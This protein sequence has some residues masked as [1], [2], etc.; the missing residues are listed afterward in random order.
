MLYM[1]SKRDTFA[2]FECLSS[3]PDATQ[4]LGAILPVHLVLSSN[5]RVGKY[6][7]MANDA[8]L[9]T[10]LAGPFQHSPALTGTCLVEC[11]QG[12][13]SSKSEFRTPPVAGAK[14]AGLPCEA[15]ASLLWVGSMTG[16][17]SVPQ[18]RGSASKR[19]AGSIHNQLFRIALV[20]R[21]L[22]HMPV[23]VPCDASAQLSVAQLMARCRTTDRSYR[24]YRGGW[25]P[26][27]PLREFDFT[28]CFEVG[29]TLL[30]LLVVLLVTSL[31]PLGK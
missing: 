23:R 2:C 8:T 30:T 15:S 19:R 12:F 28:A 14:R 21:S 10:F 7:L 5:V 25:G 4:R 31:P 26:V 27:S 18:E 29:T 24:G 20:I 17:P 9:W 1:L 22:M 13:G 3:P 6:P 16:R 11:G